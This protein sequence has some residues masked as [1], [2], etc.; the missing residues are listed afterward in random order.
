M[1]RCG[2]NQPTVYASGDLSIPAVGTGNLNF[3]A[4]V[5]DKGYSVGL[6]FSIGDPPDVASIKGLFDDAD[7]GIKKVYEMAR[8]PQIRSIQDAQKA[9]EE[10]STALKPV[11]SAVSKMKSMDKQKFSMAINVG[12]EG[13]WPV[14][15][16]VSPPIP[17]LGFTVRF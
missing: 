13:G 3:K 5:S 15:G 2:A 1:T 11:T 16:K 4:N 7:A 10:V 9:A 12:L 6:S 17:T 14:G 8:D